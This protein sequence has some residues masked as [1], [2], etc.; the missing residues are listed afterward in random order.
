MPEVRPDY[1]SQPAINNSLLDEILISPAHFQFFWNHPQQNKETT[2][3][4]NGSVLHWALNEPELF[5][6]NVLVFPEP[7]EGKDRRSVS[8]QKTKL[9]KENPDK[10][11][12]WSNDYDTIRRHIDVTVDD[13]FIRDL[14]A[15]APECEVERY[16]LSES[17]FPNEPD[18]PCK[19]R[20]DRWGS[21]SKVLIDIKTT[22]SAAPTNDGWFKQCHNMDYYRQ[23]AF[24]ADHLGADLGK[25]YFLVFEMDPPYIVQPY[26][27]TP[28]C[29]DYG[30]KR[31]ENA[32]QII[33]D[34]V[35]QYGW[36]NPWPGYMHNIPDSNG[37][38][39]SS[40]V[41][42]AVSL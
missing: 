42:W 23:I 13:P 11:V 3:M 39:E 26:I 37:C 7:E 25:V 20:A 27:L 12:L 31:Y 33:R 29:L 14:L 9:Q 10:K 17:K 41:P 38:L 18:L 19:L 16:F 6:N 5:H 8:A 1:Y 28:E 40:L 21:A 24:Y 4:R 2:R 35:D 34:C 30:R 32:L 22:T 15:S 36:E